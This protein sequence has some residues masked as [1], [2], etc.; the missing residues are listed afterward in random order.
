MD[1]KSGETIKL[2]GVGSEDPDGD[3]IEYNWIYY[4]EV[5]SYPGGL[6]IN[7]SDKQKADF[8]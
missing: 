5:G 1:V 6:K 2:S 7:D 4:R 8:V 3:E